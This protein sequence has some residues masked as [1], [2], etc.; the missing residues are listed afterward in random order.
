[1]KLIALLLTVALPAGAF[2]ETPPRHQEGGFFAPAQAKVGSS[3]SLQLLY[4][5]DS[6]NV[7]TILHVGSNA[8]YGTE[9]AAAQ[10]ATQVASEKAASVGG[11]P[12]QTPTYQCSLTILW[13]PTD[14]STVQVVPA[15]NCTGSGATALFYAIPAMTCLHDA[16]QDVSSPCIP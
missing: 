10:A 14:P 8:C 13:E 2:F 7:V 9:L 6:V 11:E 15:G 4:S 1:M 5:L 12:A 16:Q 3:C